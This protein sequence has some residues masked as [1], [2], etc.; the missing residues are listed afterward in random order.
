MV[1]VLSL[2]LEKMPYRDIMDVVK[3]RAESKGRG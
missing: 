3:L 2:K 1:V